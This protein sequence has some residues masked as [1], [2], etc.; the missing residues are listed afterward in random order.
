MSSEVSCTKRKHKTLSLREKMDIIRRLEDGESMRKLATEYGVGRATVQDIKKKKS[1]IMGHV[2]MMESGLGN[3]KTLKLGNYPEMEAALY[4]WYVQQPDEH[5]PIT[6]DILKTKAVEFY[7]KI[8]NKDDFC[9]SD[10]WFERFKKRFGI[11]ISSDSSQQSTD[12]LTVQSY[13]QALQE[14]IEEL[15]LS[16]DQVYNASKSELLPLTSPQEMNALGQIENREKITFM[17]C[18]NASGKHKLDLLVIGKSKNPRILRNICLPVFYINQSKA[19]ITRE[20]ITQWFQDEFIPEV[21]K[22]MRQSKLPEKALLILDKLP[23]HINAKDLVSSDGM[24]QT[25]I[26]PP[27]C[28]PLLQP[29]DQMVKAKYRKKLLVEFFSQGGDMSKSLEGVNLKNVIFALAQS[30]KSISSST[31]RNSWNLWSVKNEP[32]EEES[33]VE[34]D[35]PVS[36]W[37]EF[38]AEKNIAIEEENLTEWL[39][40]STVEEHELRTDDEICNEFLKCEEI[41]DLFGREPNVNYDD[42]LLSFT[43]CITW[44]EENGI[45]SEETMVLRK[46]REKAFKQK[47]V[48]EKPNNI[49]DYRD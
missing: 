17:P 9:A 49:A 1:K 19:C 4:S 30:W 44:A 38:L 35:L 27:N 22:F 7:K 34:N 14:K 18:V 12:S 39:E 13:I 25:I 26:L 24:I 45:S 46:L 40:G 21:R 8:T 20:V 11:T 10:G 47:L 2:M 6:K 16:P 28:T 48:D 29:I 15:N 33:D 42:L 31:L 5:K 41:T 43:K 37:M 32:T 23:K 3:R 36:S